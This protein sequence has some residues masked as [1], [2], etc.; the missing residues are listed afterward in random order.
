MSDAP[1]PVPAAAPPAA[2]ARRPAAP[3]SALD[4]LPP[5]R[6]PHA[7]VQLAVGVVGAGRRA[8]AHL[9][10]IAS[11]G[12][13]G[14]YRLEGV[15][16]SD[17]ERAEQAAARFGGTAYRSV[18]GLLD[19]LARSSPAVV[20]VVTPPEAHH[21]VVELAAPRGVHALCE[22]PLSFSLACADR[23]IAA[24]A[25][26]GTVLETAEN[27]WRFPEERAKR[28][29][30]DRGLVGDVGLI[31]CRYASGSYHAMNAMRHLARA[32]IASVTGD[33]VPIRAPLQARAGGGETLEVAWQA[34]LLRFANGVRGVFELPVRPGHGNHWGVD[35]A[36]G[37]LDGCVLRRGGTAAPRLAPERLTE[38]IGGVEV[39]VGLRYADH[40]WEN[41]LRGLPIPC[42]T[43]SIA[44][45]DEHLS[46]HRA[47][48]RAGPNDYG[49]E[50]GRAD[51]AAA[52]AIQESALL[53]GA[54]VSPPFSAGL[55]HDRALHAEYERRF[56]FPPEEAAGHLETVAFP[57]SYPMT[58]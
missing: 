19:A 40:L 14:Y 20:V 4:P 8:Q 38:R 18:A 17:P 56:G 51:L 47:V 9:A 48:C 33:S 15:C 25:R 16:D 12:A 21:P 45:A 31:H 35:G 5:A 49:G 34:A 41:P 43:D 28:F 11:L 13:A 3:A 32:P 6:P 10:T 52:S 58:R 26:A 24:A 39:L 29:L 44:R 53:G 36:L 54:P 50:Q 2:S 46:L 37:C 27:V 30:L 1:G 42:D 23:M 55:A 57:P 7:P 22:T